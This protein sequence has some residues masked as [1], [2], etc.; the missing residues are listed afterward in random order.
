MNLENLL[1]LLAAFI[2]GGILQ[3]I[4]KFLLDKRKQGRIDFQIILKRL[5]DDNRNIH[6]ENDLLKKRLTNLEAKI[7]L[8]ESAHHDLPIPMWLLDFD[9]SIIAVNTAFEESFLTSL[10]KTSVD[11]MGK[12]YEDLFSKED[13]IEFKKADDIVM[14]KGQVWY[15]NV[16]VMESDWRFIK[17]IRYAGKAK[18][19]I[20][21]LAIPEQV[22]HN[23]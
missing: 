4:L 15:G 6:A 23:K 1:E 19:G 20:A 7:I 13:C 10:G 3:A 17:Y 11:A 12:L 2:T 9:G 5:D 8:L 14:K 16:H 18:I 22:Y 21:C